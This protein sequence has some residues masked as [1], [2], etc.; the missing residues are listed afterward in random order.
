MQLTKDGVMN[1][2]QWTTDGAWMD[3]FLAL[4]CFSH[5]TSNRESS[6]KKREKSFSV[7]DSIRGGGG[8]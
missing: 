4:Q 1:G 5:S 7:N 6:S 2:Q 8:A 3:V